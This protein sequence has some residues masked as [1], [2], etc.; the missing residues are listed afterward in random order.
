MLFLVNTE[1]NMNMNSLSKNEI[2]H[3]FLPI[4]QTCLKFKHNHDVTIKFFLAEIFPKIRGSSLPKPVLTFVELKI[5]DILFF[6]R[7][8]YPYKYKLLDK[9]QPLSNPDFNTTIVN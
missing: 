4:F 7:L 2:S 6:F 3:I 1:E 8:K 9:I 5:S